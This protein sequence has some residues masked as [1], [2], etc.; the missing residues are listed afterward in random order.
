MTKIEQTL[1]E[2]SE[3]QLFS[4]SAALDWLQDNNKGI[5]DFN[6]WLKEQ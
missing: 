6:T 5:N 2:I 4:N 1:K 3:L